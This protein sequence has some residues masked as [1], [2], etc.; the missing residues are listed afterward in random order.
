MPVCIE[1]GCRYELWINDRLLHT[2]RI[3]LTDQTA[4]VAPEQCL[5]CPAGRVCPRQGIGRMQDTIACIEGYVCNEGTYPLIM[6]DIPC[7]EGRSP[8]HFRICQCIACSPI[9]F[10]HAH[11]H[12]HTHT[13]TGYACD[14]G[15]SAETMFDYPCDPGFICQRG[16]TFSNRKRVS[17]PVGYYWY[18]SERLL[19][20]GY[21]C[22]C[23]RMCMCVRVHN[24]REIYR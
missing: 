22:V 9:F 4:L 13:H 23:V 5:P 3:V 16:T 15:T 18:E 14:D 12:T 11:T 20:G 6:F 1:S 10:Y 7:P 24:K 21:V 17:C 19:C 8:H 2:V